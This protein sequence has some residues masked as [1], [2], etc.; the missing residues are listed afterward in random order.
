M[1]F[2][3]LLSFLSADP[4]S[5]ELSESLRKL[6]VVDSVNVIA[7]KVKAKKRIIHVLD[8]HYVDENSFVAD[9]K[10]AADEV[11]SEDETKDAVEEHRKTVR[12]VQKQ[13]RQLI[14]FLVSKLGIKQV[15][16][17]GFTQEELDPY[18]N[19]I[20]MLKEFEPPSGNGGFDQFIRH[21]YQIDLL[22][23]GAPGHLLIDEKI[24]VVLPAEGAEAYKAAN[25]LRDGKF[26]FDEKANEAREDAI[27]KR[28]L[29]GTA[30]TGVRI[31]GGAHDLSDNVPDDCEY[32]RVGEGL[33]EGESVIRRKTEE[34]VDRWRVREMHVSLGRCLLW[35]HWNRSR[36][37][38]N[39]L[40]KKLFE[41][42]PLS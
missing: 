21:E 26:V 34:A 37:L 36:F 39:Q 18:K 17:E 38:C 24:G 25:P 28:V 2:I 15:I 23:I 40:P 20:Q 6:P 32:I 27:V 31:L 33:S 30:R 11:L 35:R 1:S 22:L 19:R 16:H 14:L 3:L 41:F 13:E 10:D 7:A 42:V 4:R 9:L 5:L 29:A 8:W 12:K